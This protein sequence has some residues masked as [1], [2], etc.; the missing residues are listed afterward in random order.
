ML[1]MLAVAVASLARA[2]AAVSRA[3]LRRCPSQFV[4]ISVPLRRVLMKVPVSSNEVVSSVLRSCQQRFLSLF[5]TCVGSGDACDASRRSR[6]VSKG[7]HRRSPA[8]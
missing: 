7:L 2:C 3:D 5:C 6:S 1:N 4:E 8:R